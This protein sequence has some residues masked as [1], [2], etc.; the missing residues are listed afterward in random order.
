MPVLHCRILILILAL[1]VLS[2]VLAIGAQ[3]DLSQL[4][5]PIVEEEQ[6]NLRTENGQE[7]MLE[8]TAD[9]ITYDKNTEIYEATGDA[10]A[11]LPN[12]DS[13]LYADKIIYNG[14]T[15]LVEAFGA[16]KMVKGEGLNQTTIHGTYTSFQTDTSLLDI[17]APRVFLTGVKLKAREATGRL[18]EQK[19]PDK[20]PSKTISFHD[21]TLALEQPLT[22]YLKGFRTGTR[23]SRDT[24]REDRNAD[25]NWDDLPEKSSFKYSAKEITYDDT[26]KVNNISIKGAR[27]WL[28]DTFSIPSPVH[29]TTTI[30]D[31][32]NTKFNGP[33]IGTQERIGGFALGPRFFYAPENNIGLFS[34]APILQIGNDMS[35]GA[36][37]IA[38]YS[39]PGDTTSIMGGYGSLDDRW[40]LNAHQKL[41]YGFEVN[42]LK[43]QYMHSAMFG[44]TFV[45]ELAE[46]AHNAFLKVP[47]IDRRG[48]RFHN[49]VALAKDNA[50]LFSARRL[51]DLRESRSEAGAA[52]GNVDLRTF[53]SEHN[54]S[55]Y[56]KPVFRR[57]NEQYNISLS[58]RGQGAMR[59]YGT[60]DH[61][62]I[63]SFGPALEMR[64]DDLSLEVDYLFAAVTG[65]SPFLFDQFIDGNQS[66]V[67]D[68]DYRVSK[69][70]TIGTYLTF[71][72]DSEKFVRNQIR[73]MF[74]PD[75]FK[76]ILSYDTILNQVG[77]GF[78]MIMGDP[79][80][81]EKLDVKMQ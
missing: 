74:G 25:Y 47:L 75:D 35:F 14:T 61:L 17:T 62:G 63:A 28:S 60:G 24:V 76:L 26:K 51:T 58:A 38:T 1:S 79:L 56:T 4:Q 70:F 55:F 50:E 44:T 66:V 40:V 65:E 27:V 22:L 16:V 48:I 29:I 46:I 59:F 52:T 78:N 67:I 49:S 54:A 20:K 15:K 45:G 2:P 9:E 71:N 57:G 68:G 42:I 31:A 43:N 80:K 10:V 33:V 64:L 69:W 6:H 41:P 39:R 77:I 34:A 21:G 5:K 36:G 23:Y 32:A 19:D 72:M 81:F 12:R 18:D 53:R 3:P 37:L 73:T 8:V 30:G 7:L 13:T 11:I